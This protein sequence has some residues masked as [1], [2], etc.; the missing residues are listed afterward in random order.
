MFFSFEKKD[1]RQQQ[2]LKKGG[3][4]A[5]VKRPEIH[6]KCQSYFLYDFIPYFKKNCSQATC[7]VDFQAGS[8]VK[9][10]PAIQETQVQPL[11]RDDPLEKGLATHSNIL[12]LGNPMERGA[13]CV[14]VHGVTKESGSI[15][16][17]NNNKNLG[18]NLCTFDYVP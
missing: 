9:N 15:Q 3:E 10:P 16:Q 18:K 8:V 14:I 1:R 13:W 4:L 6:T 17:Q 2:I 12:S 7:A 5:I 11:G